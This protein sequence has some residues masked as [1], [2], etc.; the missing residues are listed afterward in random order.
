MEEYYFWSV[1]SEGPSTEIIYKGDVLYLKVW[2]IIDDIRAARGISKNG[3]KVYYY[4]VTG[5][6]IETYS[7]Y[8]TK[9]LLVVLKGHK[10][11][12]LNTVGLWRR[13]N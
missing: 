5:N 4:K 6:N 3:S 11:D 8:Y 7:D 2:S 10:I 12:K 1:N 9:N 13:R